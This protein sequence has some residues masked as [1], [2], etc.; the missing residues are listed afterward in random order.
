MTHCKHF[1]SS[2]AA[3]CPDCIFEYAEKKNEDNAKL[4]ETPKQHLNAWIV[5]VSLIVA[6]VL[7]IC[8]SAHAEEGFASYYTEASCKAEGTSGVRTANGERYDESA[9]T[10]ARPT[11]KWNT[12][13]HVYNPD[14]GKEIICRQNDFGPGKGPRAKGVVIDLTPAAFKALGCK[15]KQGKQ[16]V[17]VQQVFE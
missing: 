2:K 13:W 9:F 17:F 16:R 1:F 14:T 11:R 3:L 6:A 4:V 8:A 10:C 15:L 12:Q 7:L 5:I